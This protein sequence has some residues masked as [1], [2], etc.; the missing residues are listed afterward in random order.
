MS[1]KRLLIVS[2]IHIGREN[3]A[4]T[5]LTV[6]TSELPTNR[7]PMESLKEFLEKSQL[8]ID[9]ILN[10]GDV[11]NLGY[12]AG[13]YAGI[14]MLRELS[15]KLACPLISTPGNHDYT[16]N[17]EKK[18]EDTLLKGVKDY[19]TP[20]S[21]ANGKFWA[22]GFCLYEHDEI[23]YL[24]CNS[25]RHLTSIDDLQVS[26]VYSEDYLSRIKEELKRHPFNGIKIAIMHHHIIQ[27]SDLRNP[28]KAD[29]IE[30]G[31]KL[32]SILAEE[33][34]FCVI[35]GHKHQPRIVPWGEVKIIAC[36]SLAST[37]NTNIAMI[38]NHFHVL[39]LDIEDTVNGSLESYKFVMGSGCA[40]I[41]EPDY[42]I[43]PIEG[44]GCNVDIQDIAQK[45]VK[46]YFEDLPDTKFVPISVIRR[47]FP[48]VSSFSN[49]Q[50][51]EFGSACSKLGYEIYKHNLEFLLFKK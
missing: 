23:Q 5:N 35:H 43:K 33:K 38:N 6:A 34:F 18:F 25:E 4:S 42:P 21:N 12:P 48:L 11:T 45:V 7:N 15:L 46:H 22:E 19:P 16:L 17:G 29:V 14:R 31:D 26:P 30:N 24:I 9:A 32:L 49:K 47:D 28:Q 8:K 41:S 36:G 50:L 51:D 1:T 44:L 39:V 37:Q 20:D 27:H 3:D 10:L 2:D 40:L 13:W